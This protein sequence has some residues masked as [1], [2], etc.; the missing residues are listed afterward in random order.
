M[1]RRRTIQPSIE[2]LETRRDELVR[3]LEKGSRQIDELR[4][5]GGD[6]LEWETFWIRL[7]S[8]YESVCDELKT[9]R[10]GD[11]LAQAS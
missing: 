9:L 3:R 4:A 7:L 2:A 11:A 1:S 6:T 8:E 10:S 5:A